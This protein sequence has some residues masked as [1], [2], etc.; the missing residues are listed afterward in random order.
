VERHAISAVAAGK[1]IWYKISISYH[2]APND[3]Y[4]NSIAI[5]FGPYQVNAA[6]N[7]WEKKSKGTAIDGVA[8]GAESF[9]QSPAPPDFSGAAA[10][11][12]INEATVGRV[13]I[14][15]LA[16][17]LSRPFAEFVQQVRAISTFTDANDMETKLNNGYASRT[18]EIANFNNQV[19]ALKAQAGTTYTIL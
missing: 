14:E 1:V 9:S 16:S 7:Q 11:P 3:D 2:G 10:I 5:E 6:S 13:R 4:P 17:G 19:A 15:N 18:V 8:V 12:N